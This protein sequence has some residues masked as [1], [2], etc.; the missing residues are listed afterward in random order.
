MDQPPTSNPTSNQ[1]TQLLVEWRQGNR[2]ALH[3]LM[4][5]VHAEL[6]QLAEQYLRQERPDHTF[7]PTDL[8]HEAYL[9]LVDKT[10][11]QW[12]DRVHFFAVAAQLMRRILVD[13]ARRVQSAKRGGDVLKVP[14]EEGLD[15]AGER[16]AEVIALDDALSAKSQLDPQK[17]RIIE[18]RFFGGLTI[19]ETAEAMGLAA[20]T[21]I[22]HTRL[23]R[24]W[25]HAALY[26]D[27]QGNSGRTS[28]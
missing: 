27:A 1:V 8:V 10:H 18:L 23:A 4:P 6:R 22:K 20:P 28:A 14:L 19:E 15:V 3:R 25:L 26:P 13:H 21:V 16:A 11:P 12:Q 5:L 9:R 24:A 2:E 7:D 17:S